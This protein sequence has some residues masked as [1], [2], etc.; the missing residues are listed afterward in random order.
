[1]RKPESCSQVHT[2]SS[3]HIITPKGFRVRA[4]QSRE[5]Y[6]VYEQEPMFLKNPCS[7]SKEQRTRVMLRVYKERKNMSR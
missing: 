5:G 6:L 3:I 4:I 7:S 1:M 2:H